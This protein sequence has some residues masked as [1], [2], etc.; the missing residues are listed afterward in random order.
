MTEPQRLLFDPDASDLERALLR[1][2]DR[3]GPSAETRAR[4]LGIGGVATGA[5]VTGTVAGGSIPQKAGFAG[6]SLAK[7][8]A[9]LAVAA[10]AAA[11]ASAVVLHRSESNHH[12]ARSPG[13]VTTPAT[14]AR[15]ASTPV[16]APTD[17]A[18]PTTQDVRENTTTTTATAATRT[19]APPAL[20]IPSP[21][22]V[23]DL[24]SQVTALD[25]ARTALHEGDDARALRLVDDY[26]KRYPT[27]TFVQEAEVVRIEALTAEGDREGAEAAGTRFLALYPSSPHAARIRALM[28]P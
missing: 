13:V 26:E 27:G 21:P 6:L 23:D 10:S 8:L 11:G 2:W 7:W 5:A 28:E 15:R 3:R 12:M 9:G 4:I 1:S 19:P 18:P 17:V 20:P 14:P 25:L 24:P 16:P 22:R